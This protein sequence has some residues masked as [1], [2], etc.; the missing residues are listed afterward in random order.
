MAG[1]YL[2]L[3]GTAE[4]G[5][6]P[7]VHPVQRMLLDHAGLSERFCGG[8][9]RLFASADIPVV[10]TPSAGVVVGHVFDHGGTPIH[11]TTQLPSATE[12]AAF[13][14]ALTQQCWGE[15]VLLQ[16]ATVGAS[17]IVISRDPSGGLPCLYP[18]EGACGFVT[19]D[20]TLATDLGLYERAVDWE[21]ISQLLAYPFV[22]TAR[23]GLRRLREVLP[24]CSLHL[25]RGS[26]VI[27]PHWS[28]WDFVAS[29][30]SAPDFDEAAARI[31]A[32][33][34][35]VVR[36]WSLVDRSVLLE[37]S[38]GL[39]SSI[40]AACLRQSPARVECATLV[41]ALPGADERPYA[42][43]VAERAGLALHAEVLTI[44]RSRLLAPVPPSLVTPR[45]GP[46]QRVVDD[47]MRDVAEQRKLECFF[48]GGG[49]DTVFAYLPGAAPAADA[50]L[51]QGP[52]AGLKA[53]G[54]LSNLHQCT[55]WKAAR[56][57]LRKLRSPSPKPPA[58][59]RSFLTQRLGAAPPDSHPWSSA[60]AR[61]APGDRERILGLAGTQAFRD[62]LPRSAS[63]RL[64]LPL[65]SQPILEAC[66]AVPSWLWIAGGINRA[67]ARAAFADVLPANVAQRRSKGDF[68]QYCAA[69]Y[70]HHKEEM[71]DLLLTGELES[72]GWL[73]T[74]ALTAFFDRPPSA[75]DETFMRLFD[76]CNV[77]NWLR[78]QP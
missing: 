70:R 72:R 4:A 47:V 50:F 46:L 63:H 34:E 48:S 36:S 43:A 14:D 16:P 10:T 56:L 55:L 11:D 5:D 2:A 13:R 67:V 65:L 27:C 21:T 57:T 41:T 52:M 39:D 77:E 60:P 20:I 49:G 78:Q 54:D 31:R 42:S 76:L 69:I 40:L 23:T 17:E 30:R 59:N 3:F 18:S 29:G 35:R 15:Y 7:A 12:P 28:P 75:R 66:L 68:T 38:G 26:A 44:E 45:A 33:V 58:A 61:A 71:R 9:V 1:R 25:E 24:G 19:S 62:G 51:K 37:L 53:I 22:K 74:D 6:A 64:R 8:G 32:V 73:D